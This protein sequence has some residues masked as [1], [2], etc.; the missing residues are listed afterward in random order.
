MINIP[1]DFQNYHINKITNQER[2]WAE[3]IRLQTFIKYPELDEFV[4]KTLT[5]LNLN[6]IGQNNLLQDI[7]LAFCYAS[8]EKEPKT[9]DQLLKIVKSCFKIYLPYIVK[10]LTRY[11]LPNLVQYEPKVAIA[12]YIYDECYN[13]I[14]N[15][16]DWQCNQKHQDLAE[17]YVLWECLNMVRAARST[18]LLISVGD[19]V[20]G[21]SVFR[22]VLEI[23]FK[24]FYVEAFKNEYV[25]FKEFNA[26]LQS[27]RDTGAPF[28]KK[29]VD[30][31]DS[32]GG[33]KG[34]KENFL[35]YGW[36]K[37]KSGNRI[38]SFS[39]LLDEMENGESW[40]L[41]YH[42]C[43]EF[44]HEDYVAVDY[45]YVGLRKW[46]VEIQ[47]LIVPSVVDGLTEL[48]NISKS[49]VKSVVNALRYL[50]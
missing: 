18:L 45:D 12:L 29:M 15:Q 5:P 32:I 3:S 31:I 24:L 23:L 46:I 1:I 33:F 37:D 6:K 41:V 4:E 14:Q 42:I 40:K 13:L 17:I 38:L 30:Y 50:Q 22:G 25:L 27:N 11:K 35:A 7:A 19:D 28:P 44:V 26:Y 21:V 49:K 48:T 20:H 34:N 43:S 36:I 2:Q 10:N 8:I 39:Q 9:T 16:I 47:T